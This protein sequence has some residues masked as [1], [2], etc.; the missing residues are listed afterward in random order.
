MG[1]KCCTECFTDAEIGAY[2]KDVG[3]VSTCDYCKSKQVYCASLDVVGDFIRDGVERAYEAVYDGT[4]S[5]YDSETKSYTDEGEPIE[6]I[7]KWDLSIFSENLDY[8]QTELLCD[9]LISESGPSY[10]DIQKGADNWL[11]EQNL[12]V[13][14]ALY[15]FE[16]TPQHNY[17]ETFKHNC[18]Y[19]NRYFDLGGWKSSRAR[20]LSYLDDVFNNMKVELHLK[21]TLFRSRFYILQEGKTLKDIDLLKEISPP[22]PNYSRNSRMSPAGMSYTYLASDIDT[23][24]AEIRAQRDDKVLIGTFIT[25]KKLK[26]LDLSATPLYRVTS[27]FSPGYDHSKNWLGDFIEH[28]RNEISA[29]ISDSDKD[30]EYVATQLLAEYIRKKRFHG[31]KFKSSLNSE[32][33]NYV[34]FCSINPQ[35]TCVNDVSMHGINHQMTPFTTWLNLINVQYMNCTTAYEK[36]EEIIHD[37][38]TA[39]Y[40]EYEQQEKEFMLKL[41]KMKKNSSDDLEF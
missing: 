28:F 25:K 16:I 40:H 32:G 27:C 23:C 5:M 4:G 34:L 33:Y 24:L 26:I 10:R 3:E 41:K 18:K 20:F 30:I 13:R 37:D 1:Q 19:F 39:N 9:D 2:I 31:I 22:P 6:A 29:P 38:K 14:D 21:T 17:W 35:I 11:A 15:G 8:N 36:V 12:V 7:L